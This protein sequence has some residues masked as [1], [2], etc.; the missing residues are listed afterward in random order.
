MSGC[1][2]Y[3]YMLT[4]RNNKM[5]HVNTINDRVR[6]IYE[7]QGKLLNSFI[8]EYKVNKLVYYETAADLNNAIERERE[9]KKLKRDKKNKLVEA[10]NP[11]W[12]NLIYRLMK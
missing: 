8:K 4:N 9:I 3:I 11:N 5:I 12:T 1:E 2:Y 7:S 10:M 6:K